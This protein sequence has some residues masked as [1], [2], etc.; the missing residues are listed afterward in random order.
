MGT[1][2][3]SSL[4]VF[5]FLFFFKVGAEEYGGLNAGCFN[6]SHVFPVW[7]KTSSAFFLRTCSNFQY[8]CFLTRCHPSANR[9]KPHLCRTSIL[10]WAGQTGPMLTW[11]WSRRKTKQLIGRNR[12]VGTF[13][14]DPYPEKETL[15]WISRKGFQMWD[16]LVGQCA[17]EIWWEP[18]C[19]SHLTLDSTKLWRI[20]LREHRLV[21][22]NPEGMDWRSDTTGL[23]CLWLSG[24][25]ECSLLKPVS[26]IFK[27]EKREEREVPIKQLQFKYLSWVPFIFE[28][29]MLLNP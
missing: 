4:W 12:E 6:T 19:F 3:F 13:S 18:H 9:E 14:A 29:K 5:L 28:N 24:I 17:I 26:Y 27:H 23:L 1:F 16:S 15:G 21:C 7:L 2:V 11:W 8:L 22:L 25:S 10:S 20:T